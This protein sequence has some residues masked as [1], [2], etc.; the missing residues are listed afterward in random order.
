MLWGMG[1]HLKAWA[2]RRVPMLPL[3]AVWPGCYL[4]L[5]ATNCQNHLTSVTVKHSCPSKY[6]CP[7]P[8]FCW[9]LPLAHAKP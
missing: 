2:Y 3:A 1:K 5:V 4:A 9:K 7:I 8:K 6:R